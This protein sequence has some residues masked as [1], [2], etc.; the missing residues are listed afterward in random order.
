MKCDVREHPYFGRSLFA[1]NG[2]IEV[3]IPLEYGLRIG[4][5]SFCG[6]KNVFFEQPK[7]MVDLTTPEGWRVHCGHRLWLAPESESVYYPDNEP[8]SYEIR[9]QGIW[10]CQKEDPW[11][12]VKKSMY[13]SFGREE[14]KDEHCLTV[15]HKV[16]N[17]GNETIKVALWAVTA[18]AAGGVEHIPLKRYDGGMDPKQRICAW[19]HTDLGDVRAKYAKDEITLTHMPLDEQFKIGIGHPDGRVWYEN[20]GVTF[21]LNF[22]VETGKEYPDGNVSYESFMCKHMVELESLSPYAEILPGESM[23]YQEVWELRK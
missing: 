10:I 14:T 5:F 22:P 13:L 9:E 15:L 1:D 8:I 23:E 12:Q 20:D 21:V 6:D 16:V 3:G 7:D 18:M 4:H 19:Y 2:T 17:T 11:L